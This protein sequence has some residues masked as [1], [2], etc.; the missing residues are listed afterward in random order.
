MSTRRDYVPEL[1]P[2]KDL[3]FIPTVIYEQ[4][5]PRWNDIERGNRKKKLEEKTC[6]SAI[7]PTTYPTWTDQETDRSFRGDRPT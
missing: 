1:R 3:L 6:S 5:E 7:L 4:E 2:T